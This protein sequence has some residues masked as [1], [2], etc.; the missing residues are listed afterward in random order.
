[1]KPVSSTGDYQLSF[2]ERISYLYA[3]VRGE[4]ASL[5]IARD[6]WNRIAKRAL[7]LKVKKVLVVE[8]I[9]E[10]IT[11]SEVHQLVTELSELPVKDIFVAFVDRFAQHK[12]INEFGM[13][14][15][16]NR[17]LEIRGFES[18]DD[19]EKW[20]LSLLSIN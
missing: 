17:G 11:I 16:G 13:L 15:G 5:E 3:Y 7:S 20:L 6:Y 19:A 4:H 1:M 8:D 10:A 12:S 14:V 18:T 9:S 2:E